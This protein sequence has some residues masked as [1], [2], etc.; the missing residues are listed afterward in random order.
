MRKEHKKIFK[1]SEEIIAELVKKHSE[2][3]VDE[4]LRLNLDKMKVKVLRKIIEVDSNKFFRDF[5]KFVEEEKCLK[6]AM[7]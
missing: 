1:F 4:I 3:I 5:K 7:K 6:K 2:T